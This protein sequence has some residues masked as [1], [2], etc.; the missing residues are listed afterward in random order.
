[1]LRIWHPIETMTEGSLLQVQGEQ[2]HHLSRV[3]RVRAGE[4][5]EVLA[6]EGRLLRTQFVEARGKAV[7]LKVDHCLQL[8]P[9]TVQIV[10]G[11]AWLKGKAMEQVIRDAVQLGADV[12]CPLLTERTE[13]R[14]DDR[15]REGKVERWLQLAEESCK[16]CGNPWLPQIDA[17]CQLD[18]WLRGLPQEKALRLHASLGEQATLLREHFSSPVHQLKQVVWLIGPEG[19]FSPQEYQRIA[20]S[21]F[22]PVR[23]SSQILRAETA[24]NYALAITE[25]ELAVHKVSRGWNYG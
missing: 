11:V 14:L 6:G 17:P 19:D 1:M 23:L 8:Q 9:R 10:L 3:L 16:Q 5:V 2:A 18:E 12:I 13:V 21:S 25:Y 7:F 15:R 4:T 22:S 24:V 20:A